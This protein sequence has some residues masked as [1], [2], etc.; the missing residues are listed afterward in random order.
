MEDAWS[1]RN[2]NRIFRKCTVVSCLDKGEFLQVPA[3]LHVSCLS[4]HKKTKSEGRYHLEAIIGTTAL[5]HVARRYRSHGCSLCRIP[6]ASFLAT[7]RMPDEAHNKGTCG[8]S[9]P[10]RAM[11]SS[12]RILC[13]VSIGRGGTSVRRRWS[14]WFIAAG[15]SQHE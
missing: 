14:G 6:V 5:D 3:R 11:Y 8:R 13:E 2:G 4:H 12:R 7:G 1:R 9:G 15:A 10:V